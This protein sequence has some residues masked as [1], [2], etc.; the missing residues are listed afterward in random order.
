MEGSQ[1]TLHVPGI[2]DQC[3]V[4][5]SGNRRGNIMRAADVPD[6]NTSILARLLFFSHL[7][8]ERFCI[9]SYAGKKT[10]I[11]STGY[12]HGRYQRTLHVP[13]IMDQCLVIFSGNRRGNIVR[14]ADVPDWHTSP[15]PS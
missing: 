5:F 10:N 12:I 6:W 14:A 9:V 1:R 7:T 8:T 2:M 13:W 3:L 15:I 4:I 11:S